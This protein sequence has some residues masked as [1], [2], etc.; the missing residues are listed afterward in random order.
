LKGFYVSDGLRLDEFDLSTD[1]LIG[2]MESKVSM[3]MEAADADTAQ[4][5][6]ELRRIL[7]ELRG[8]LR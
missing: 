4:L 5:A 6:R 3:L 8:L 2:S 1:K 7:E